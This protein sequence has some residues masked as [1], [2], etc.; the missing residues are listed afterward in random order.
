MSA[1]GIRYNGFR[2]GFELTDADGA[3]VESWEQCNLIPQEGLDFLILAPFGDTPTIP[4]WYVGLFRNPYLPTSATRASD[5]PSGLGEFVNYSEATR[6]LWEREYDN[7]AKLANE[8]SRARFTFTQDQNIYGAFIVSSSAKGSGS[9]RL[10]S[11]V[12]FA[13]PRPITNGLTLNVTSGLTYI[14][15]NIV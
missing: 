8:G 6:P 5:I 11:V 2:Y 15:T 1:D 4:A 9:G 7:V 13:S 14:P 3:V 10:L 12:R